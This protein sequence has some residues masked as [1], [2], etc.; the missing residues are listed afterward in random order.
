MRLSQA[1]MPEFDYEMANL[2]K[3]LERVPEDKLD[4]KP[5]EKSMTMRSLTTHLANMVGWG[6]HIIGQ[7]SLDVAPAGESPLRAQPVSSRQETLEMFDH[8][9]AQTR[10]A[11]SGAS[12][13]QLLKPWTLSFGGKT[14][15]TMPRVACLRGFLMNHMIHHRAQLGVYLRLNDVPVPSLYGPTADEGAF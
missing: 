5:H 11:I 6:V 9:V 7:D 13:E 15:F 4:W 2:R 3:T 10:A 14:I 1:L 12:D 8:N